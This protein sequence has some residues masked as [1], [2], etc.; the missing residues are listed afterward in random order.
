MENALLPQAKQCPQ[1]TY[2]VQWLTP[3]QLSYEMNVVVE[4]RDSPSRAPAQKLAGI[5]SCPV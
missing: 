1:H 2:N 4:C 3:E 5:W